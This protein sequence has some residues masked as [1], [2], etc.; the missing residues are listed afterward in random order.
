MTDFHETWYVGSASDFSPGGGSCLGIVFPNIVYKS[1]VRLVVKYTD[2]FWHS[3]LTYKQPGDFDRAVCRTISAR[4][5]VYY[6]L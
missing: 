3:G 1:Y 4:S 5:P 6:L 2:V